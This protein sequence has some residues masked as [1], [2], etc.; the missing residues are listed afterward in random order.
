MA[1]SDTLSGMW[2]I[3][4]AATIDAIAYLTI[5]EVVARAVEATVADPLALPIWGVLITFPGS[6][7]VPASGHLE[8]AIILNTAL[9][10]VVIAVIEKQRRKGQDVS[11]SAQSLPHERDR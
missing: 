11:G 8:Y 1:V 9:I 5:F 2:L 7:L 4:K 3:S 6:I 10:Y